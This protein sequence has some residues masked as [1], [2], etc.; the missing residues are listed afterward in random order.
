MVNA[1]HPLAAQM[2]DRATALD[3]KVEGDATVLYVA[4]ARRL[5]DVPAIR[6]ALSATAIP[7]GDRYIL[8]GSELDAVDTAGGFVLLRQLAE[9]GYPP[10]A[11][12]ERRFDA[13]HQRLLAL[14]RARMTTGGADI[15]TGRRGP[16]HR[17][18]VA[19]VAVGEQLQR[20]ITFAGQSNV[21]V[22]TGASG[23]RCGATSPPT[24]TMSPATGT[25]DRWGVHRAIG[26]IGAHEPVSTSI[27]Q[28]PTVAPL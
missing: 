17:I 25:G 24:D 14:V 26:R 12:A 20:D 19:I 15:R 21:I 8:D 13:K 4:G 1:A 23:W 10:S 7:R 2:S 5:R 3:C 22:I 18:G 6:R 27:A 28:R 16:L 9:L 11:G